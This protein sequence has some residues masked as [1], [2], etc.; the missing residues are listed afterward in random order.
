MTTIKNIDEYIIYES[1]DGGKT[2]YARSSLSGQRELVKVDE[3]KVVEHRWF[4]WKDILLASE[5]SPSLANAIKQAELI[6]E[7]IKQEQNN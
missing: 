6:Y 3:S 7:I 5:N 4:K 2:V 1:P